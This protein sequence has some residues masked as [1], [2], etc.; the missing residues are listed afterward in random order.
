MESRR[1][2]TAR[3][4]DE[5]EECIGKLGDYAIAQTVNPEHV[6]NELRFDVRGMLDDAARKYDLR[7]WDLKAETLQLLKSALEEAMR[8]AKRADAVWEWEVTP[9]MADTACSFECAGMKVKYS[10]I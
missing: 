4:L 7:A 3:A 9:F 5:I 8:T 2:R 1:V 10:I 6:C